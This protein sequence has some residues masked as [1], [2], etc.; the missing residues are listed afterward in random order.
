MDRQG[1]L[2]ADHRNIQ[3]N[4]GHAALAARLAAM[5]YFHESARCR[6][7]EGIANDLL[8]FNNQEFEPSG[9]HI[10]GIVVAS[11]RREAAPRAERSLQFVEV[12]LIGEL[13]SMTERGTCAPAQSGKAVDIK[14]FAWCAVGP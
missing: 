14:Q 12:R 11:K 5:G 3:Q 4:S 1:R 6:T 7:P 9:D 13:E 10:I 2:P 8:G